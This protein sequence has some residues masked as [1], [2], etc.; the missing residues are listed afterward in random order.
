MRI[1]EDIQNGEYKYPA[2]CLTKVFSLSV[3]LCLLATQCSPEAG[4]PTVAVNNVEVTAE[5]IS[6][7]DPY[8]QWSAC[9]Q[10]QAAVA[11]S[12]SLPLARS[13]EPLAICPK[14]LP[15]HNL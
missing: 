1:I 9:I 4:K 7:V 10:H 2:Q 15:Q 11:R 8:A 5:Q 13:D 14:F 6:G 3:G 12:I